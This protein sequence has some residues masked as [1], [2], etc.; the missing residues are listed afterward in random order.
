MFAEVRPNFRR[1]VSRCR[2]EHLAEYFGQTSASDEL[3]PIS[4]QQMVFCTT[5]AQI[6]GILRQVPSNII[7]YIV[8]YHFL[9]EN[10][11]SYH[12]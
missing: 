11:F 9:T 10:Y 2:A 7:F 1:I 3:R 12:V 5:I 4:S 8:D 6:H